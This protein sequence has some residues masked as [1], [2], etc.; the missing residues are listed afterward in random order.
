MFNVAVWR[1]SATAQIGV[2]LPDFGDWCFPVRL[3]K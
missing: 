2:D 1:V 3:G